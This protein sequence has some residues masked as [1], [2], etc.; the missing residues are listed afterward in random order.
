MGPGGNHRRG[1]VVATRDTDLN[2]NDDESVPVMPD[3]RLRSFT[4]DGK[5]P[6]GTLADGT[7]VHPAAV[8]FEAQMPAG[9]PRMI[10]RPNDEG[11]TSWAVE[12]KSK[13]GWRRFT[14]HHYRR[15]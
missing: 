1:E 8:A 13:K 2:E 7:D 14:A 12:A 4:S 3:L 5:Q 9:L 11:G 6:Q 15:T 10:Y